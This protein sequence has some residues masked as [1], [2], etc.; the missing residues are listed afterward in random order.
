M[1]TRYWKWRRADG[2]A[3]L[4]V[5]TVVATVVEAGRNCCNLKFPTTTALNFIN[6]NCL[7][8]IVRRFKVPAK[9]NHKYIGGSLFPLIHLWSIVASVNIEKKPD[10]NN[11]AIVL[12][13]WF[14]WIS[15]SFSNS[16]C[17]KNIETRCFQIVMDAS[18][19]HK[20]F[21]VRPHGRSRLDCR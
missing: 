1:D 12:K 6:S 11:T 4:K 20:Y 17:R 21:F 10:V 18:W 13:R 5:A 7:I 9:V 19:K 8:M 3:V 15:K 16:K 14:K 2:Y